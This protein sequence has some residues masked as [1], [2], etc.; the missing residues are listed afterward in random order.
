MKPQSY[1]LPPREGDE[2]VEEARSTF[3]ESFIKTQGQCPCVPKHARNID[4]LCHCKEYRES[5]VCRCG[6][7][8]KK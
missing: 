2:I 6:L 7:Y 4:T 5:G 8:R 1:P 3:A